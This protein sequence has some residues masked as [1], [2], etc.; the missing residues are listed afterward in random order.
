MAGYTSNLIG[1]WHLAANNADVSGRPGVGYVKPEDRGG[2]DDLWE[3]SNLLEF[4][5]H[6]Y[7]GTLWDRDGKEIT[8]KDEYRVDFLTDRA[9][10]FLREKHDKPFILFCFAT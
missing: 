10:R 8:W 4:T 5:S 7:E 6:P 2:F 1:K 9:E 3:G